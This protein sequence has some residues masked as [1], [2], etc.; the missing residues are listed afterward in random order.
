MQRRA[1]ILAVLS[2]FLWL[3]ARPARADFCFQVDDG[4]TGAFFHFAGKYSK[5][6][7]KAKS[8]LGHV[9]AF[10]GGGVVGIGPAF[11]AT[12]GLPEG[13]AG[14]A[15]SVQ[16]SFGPGTVGWVAATLDDNGETQGGGTIYYSNLP[17]V[18][19]GAAIAD[20]STEPQP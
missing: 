3:G 9:T 5:K 10:N 6:P 11:G 7:L 20:C 2:G 4:V 12:F 1:L 17:T 18:T 14:V 15:F 8:L 16:F 13:D 19:G